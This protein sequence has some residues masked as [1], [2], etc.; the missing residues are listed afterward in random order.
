MTGDRTITLP[1]ATG[2]VV[3]QDDTATLSNKTI[4]LDSNT[5]TGTLAEF[6]SALQGDSFVSLTGSETLTNKT[7]T[8][9]TINAA[10]VSGAVAG[11]FTLVFEG[12]RR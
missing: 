5:V 11:N 3:L 10:T 7:L 2:T 1:N 9:P 8:A 6:N 4:D 12:A